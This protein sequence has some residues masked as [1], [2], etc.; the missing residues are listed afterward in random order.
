LRHP[1][2]Q[3]L[4]VT[5]A[6]EVTVLSETFNADYPDVPLISFGLVAHTARTQASH[7]KKKYSKT[8]THRLTAMPQI[9][10]TAIPIT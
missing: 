10:S 3:P 4:V 9:D 7:K 8:K 5:A 1:S 6:Q 2:G